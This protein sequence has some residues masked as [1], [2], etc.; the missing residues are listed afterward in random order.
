[1]VEGGEKNFVAYEL[2]KRSKYVCT[3]AC[4]RRITTREVYTKKKKK[5][6]EKESKIAG[7]IVVSKDYLSRTSRVAFCPR[8]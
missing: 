1:M 4:M 3:C 7:Q 8:N 5:R 6:K 2:D